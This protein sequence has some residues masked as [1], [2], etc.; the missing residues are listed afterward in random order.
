MYQHIPKCFHASQQLSSSRFY[1]KKHLN[2]VLNCSCVRVLFLYEID[3]K[4]VSKFITQ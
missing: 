2:K 4:E 3:M 1:S